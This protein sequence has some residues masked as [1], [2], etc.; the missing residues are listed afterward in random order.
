MSIVKRVRTVFTGVA[1]TPWYSNLY[2][3]GSVDNQSA[4]DRVATF[5]NGML[6]M[7]DNDVVVT[8][9]GEVTSIT[10]E[11]GVVAGLDSVDPVVQSGQNPVD[12][13]PY[14]NQL[15]L[16]LHT[17][18]YVA[19]REVR[20]RCFVPGLCEDNT[21]GGSFNGAAV[22][23]ANTAAENLRSAGLANNDWVVYSRK[24]HRIDNIDS[25]VAARKPAV[26]R[27]RRD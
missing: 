4:V 3:L 7:I 27:S 18:E 5:W 10:V 16:A 17:G 9:E 13:L 24:N 12:P 15:L 11:T 1:G 19:G 26:L 6:L 23:M 20:G 22:A 21:T 8:T 25:A 14:S 2:F